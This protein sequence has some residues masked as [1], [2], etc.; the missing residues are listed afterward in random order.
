MVGIS[1]RAPQS[2]DAAS[3]GGPPGEVRQ[4]PDVSFRAP[5][6]YGLG[7]RV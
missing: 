5:A 7:F 2:G 6:N 1:A 4:P 3:V